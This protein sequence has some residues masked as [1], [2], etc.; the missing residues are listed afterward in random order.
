MKKTSSELIAPLLSEKNVLDFFMQM[1][2][3]FFTR[4]DLKSL[5]KLLAKDF[6]SIGTAVHEISTTLKEADK[7]FKADL[8]QVPEPIT[9]T[10][11]NL[12]VQILNENTALV[13]GNFS[14][15][16]TAEKQMFEVPHTRITAVVTNKANALKL[17]HFHFSLPQEDPG[18]PESF[19]IRRLTDALYETGERFR[20]VFENAPVGILQFDCR[21]IIK[22]CNNKFLQ[23]MKSS[24]EKILGLDM[25]NLKDKKASEATRQ[26][27]EG[28][29]SYYNGYYQATTSN[30]ITPLRAILTPM[31]DPKGLLLGGIGIY[32]DIS[33]FKDAENRLQY[34]FSF[35]RMVSN[36]STSFVNASADE[37]DAVIENALRLSNSISGKI[38]GYK[39][40][41]NNIP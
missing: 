31:S 29:I 39:W 16:G 27:L 4:R 12:K 8:K 10:R 3:A 14:L 20:Q 18:D 37:I 38:C 1:I 34:H 19:P 17:S 40:K 36:I 9:I 6:S 35:E 41:F 7:L 28:Q 30:A 5:K 32:E 15:S 13:F 2:D 23:I 21:G 33:D 24:R 22:A 11:E 26:A 25:L